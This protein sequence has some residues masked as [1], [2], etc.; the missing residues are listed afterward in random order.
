MQF[1]PLR[2]SGSFVQIRGLLPLLLMA[3][4]PA[5]RV[6]CGSCSVCLST[7]M[8]PTTA[9]VCCFTVAVARTQTLPSPFESQCGWLAVP[10]SE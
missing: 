6:L 8:S 3:S 7:W 9:W 4:E 10:L 1:L 5:I 2:S